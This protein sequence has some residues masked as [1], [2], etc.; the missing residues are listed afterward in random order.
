MRLIRQ[1]RCLGVNGLFDNRATQIVGGLGVAVLQLQPRQQ[2]VA[3]RGPGRHRRLGEQV[4]GMF[5]ERSR[6]DV[7]PVPM[8]HQRFIQV[9]QRQPRDVAFAAEQL[10]R[11]SEQAACARRIAASARRDREVGHRLRLFVRHPQCAEL[12]A[13]AFGELGGFI[14]Q[15]QFE[16]HLGAIQV[17]ERAVIGVAHALAV[18]TSRAI[19]LQRP[20]IFTA[21]IVQVGDVVVGLRDEERHLVAVAIRPRRVVGLQ[22]AGEV[23]EIDLTEGHVAQDGR[24]V[25]RLADRGQL[26]VRA[27]IQRQRLVEPILP[28]H[29]VG[30]VAVETS[31]I[32]GRAVLLE[33]RSCFCGGRQRLVI[34]AEGDE[35]LKCAIQRPRPIHFSARLPKQPCRGLV[36]LERGR[37]F[38]LKEPDMPGRP[39]ALRPGAGV[40]ELVRNPSRRAR[41][42]V[43]SLQVDPRHPHDARVEVF[44]DG[45]IPE[46]SVPQQERRAEPGRAEFSEPIDQRLPRR[47]RTRGRHLRTPP[48]RASSAGASDSVHG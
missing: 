10:P 3:Q 15:V 42:A 12:H 40:V 48:A 35:T 13:R 20:R 23:T 45:R 11:A 14:A 4:A 47:H 17:A 2:Q 46:L 18:L 36:L 29:D 5:R 32:D 6:L 22:R 25:L 1:D 37:V 9:D 30:D 44:D 38:A 41:Q 16:I 39:Q 8:E 34:P 43:G 26:L 33:E 31:Q 24:D 7:L 21:Q 28:G 19:Q 27:A